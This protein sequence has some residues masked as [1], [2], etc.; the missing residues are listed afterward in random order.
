[1]KIC[2]PSKMPF[3]LVYQN[4][5]VQTVIIKIQST[6]IKRS[7]LGHSKSGLIRQVTS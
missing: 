7:L 4:V 5:L 6:G 2:K 3:G 1:V